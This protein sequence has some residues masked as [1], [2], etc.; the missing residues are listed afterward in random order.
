MAGMC[1]RLGF[2]SSREGDV[3]L[4]FM[5]LC[6]FSVCLRIIFLHL[7]PPAPLWFLLTILLAFRMHHLRGK[8]HNI[9][10]SPREKKNLKEFLWRAFNSLRGNYLLLIYH[11]KGM[12]NS[13]WPVW[14]YVGFEGPGQC[15]LYLLPQPQRSLLPRDEGPLLP[16]GLDM[17][18]CQESETE[19]KEWG[20][21]QNCYATYIQHWQ[22]WNNGTLVNQNN[23]FLD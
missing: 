15:A 7:L 12:R 9:Q 6:P 23:Y 1:W 8:H 19:R 14:R 20:R 10:S 18:L 16:P 21:T 11:C 5:G 22:R 17:A 2:H 3:H 4:L 13:D